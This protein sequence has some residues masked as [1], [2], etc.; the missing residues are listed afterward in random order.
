MKE[1]VHDTNVALVDMDGVLADFDGYILSKL[2]S[3]L[4]KVVRKSFYLNKDYPEH[5]DLIWDIAGDDRFFYEL[6][7]VDNALRGWERLM[8]E[9]YDPRICSAPLAH[10]NKSKEGKLYWLG[11]HIVPR[12]GKQVVERAII[13]RNKFDHDGLVLIDDRPVIDT[14]QGQATWQHV[15]FDHE[16]NQDSNAAFR[17]HGWLDSALGGI[18][19]DARRRRNA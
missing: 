16:Y 6:P 17:L 4:T 15:V 9:G 14:N 18:L 10:N 2:P 11:E 13:D 7:V 8:E 3:G 1:R 19:K 12:F 5:N